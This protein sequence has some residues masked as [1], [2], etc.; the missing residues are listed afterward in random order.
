ME[1]N[2]LDSYSIKA[3]YYPT[4]IVVTPICLVILS[5]ASKQFDLLKDLGV[6]VA[7]GLGLIF[8]MDQV[9]RDGGR[10]K[11]PELFR[12]WGG[13]PTTVLLRHRDK[14][15]DAITKARY[16]RIL[17][18][19]LHN[20]DVPSEHQENENPSQADDVYASCTE[21]LKET[22]RDHSK[23]PL[24]FQENTNYGF[25]RNLWGMRPAG[26]ILSIVGTVVCGVLVFFRLL[27]S[28]G[29]LL[30]PFSSTIL[31]AVLLSF[32]ICRFTAS[33][34]RMAAYVYAR[35]LLAAC[36]SLQ[37]AREARE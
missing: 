33:W 24:V 31:S 13:V 25:R 34:V 7:S 18:E 10:N 30:I 37:K 2:A 4:L 36:D 21:F 5:L 6:V 15:I 16:H 29:D 27:E 32:W 11:Q 12:R 20:L 35:Q 26:I 14:T 3:R 23:F 22:T 28:A 8:V 19:S 9:G 17:S 1:F